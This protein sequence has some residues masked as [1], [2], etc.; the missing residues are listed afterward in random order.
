MWVCYAWPK[1]LCAARESA[2]APVRPR[3]RDAVASATCSKPKIGLV[4]ALPTLPNMAVCKKAIFPANVEAMSG[5]I[6]SASKMSA[7]VSSNC[8]TRLGWGRTCTP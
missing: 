7:M 4:T 6:L 1:A 5:D 3:E 8:C 2:A